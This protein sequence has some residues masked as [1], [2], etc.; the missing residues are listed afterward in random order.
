MIKLIEPCEEYLSSYQEAYDEY[1]IKGVSMHG[2]TN[3]QETDVLAKIQ[4]YRLGRNLNPGRVRSDSNWLV[5]DALKSFIGVLRL[6]Y[7]LN[8]SLRLRGGHIGYAVRYSCWNQG[9]GT[10]MLSLVLEKAK[11]R[12]L[13]KVLCTCNDDNPASA[14]VMEH[15][16]FLLDD[17]VEVDG[18]L[19]RRYWKT[20]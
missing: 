19:I 13:T 15:N 4:N 5:D 12:G 6:R 9:Y 16:G 3:P 17:K 1:E 20:L 2:L 18:T 14:R 10:K 8:E 7:T 11:E